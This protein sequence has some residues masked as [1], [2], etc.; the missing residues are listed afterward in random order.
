MK[1]SAAATSGVCPFFFRPR[2]CGAVVQD[3]ESAPTSPTLDSSI[4][5]VLVAL[6]F[7][8]L[9]RLKVGVK[10][11]VIL[12]DYDSIK[13]VLTRKEVLNRTDNFILERTGVKGE[14]IS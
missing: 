4:T 6:T 13:D 2:C 3:A 7:A 11:I 14:W 10:D 12:N 9:F 1:N 8:S 5:N